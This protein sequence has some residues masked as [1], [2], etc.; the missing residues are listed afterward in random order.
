[1]ADLADDPAQAAILW[2][3]AGVC[4]LRVYEPDRAIQCFR[5]AIEAAQ[6]GPSDGRRLSRLYAH[7]TAACYEASRM[8][9]AWAAAHQALLLA[10]E[11]DDIEATGKALYNLGL[12]ERYLGEGSEALKLFAASRRN[13]QESGNAASAA[14]A[15]HNMGWVQLDR[16]EL[17]EAERS[18]LAARAERTALWLPVGR[19]DLELARLA[20]KRGNWLAALAQAVE[21]AESVEA[22]TDPV[23]KLQALILAA[24]ASERDDLA[25]AFYYAGEALALGLSLGRPPALLDL[26]PV[27]VRLHANA[28]SQMPAEERALAAELFERRH[29]MQGQLQA[30]AVN[31]N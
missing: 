15:L 16:G 30:T 11:F 5:Q 23:T 2:N 25:A 7:L 31:L 13:F 19:I 17:E 4:A 29:G 1:A 26:M 3:N 28:G 20:L 27:I 8:R 22:A 14:D 9:E 6:M 21:I 12:A 10:E 18:L 24:E